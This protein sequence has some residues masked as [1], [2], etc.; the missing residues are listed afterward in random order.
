MS[1][2][3]D[4]EALVRAR[5]R[6]SGDLVHRAYAR[7]DHRDTER[8]RAGDRDQQTGVEDVS[9]QP[10]DEDQWQPAQVGERDPRTED[11]RARR[12]LGPLLEDR[13]SWNLEKN[14][15][16]PQQREQH[17]GYPKSRAVT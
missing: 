13:H 14:V 1:N 16:Q 10:A 15:R 7:A 8:Y 6:R 9:E 5:L 17:D 12:R 3:V 2:R 4:S 11:P